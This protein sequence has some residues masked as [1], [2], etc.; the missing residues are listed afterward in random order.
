MLVTRLQQAAFIALIIALLEGI[1][2]AGMVRPTMIPPPHDIFRAF[3]QAISSGFI[4]EHLAATFQR[5]AIAFAIAT[6]LGILIGVGLWRAPVLGKALE[7]LIASLYAM[8]WIFFYPLLLILLGIGSKPII[9]LAVILGVIPIALNTFIGF[10][11]IRP[12]FLKV[13]RATG[14]SP[15]QTFYK[16]L[17]PAAA[18]Y[19]ISGMKLGFI[20]TFLGVVATE[21]LVSPKGLGF[22]VHFAYEYFQV[23]E[24][25]AYVLFMILLAF[26]LTFSLDR[27]ERALRGRYQ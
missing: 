15:W 19:I 1:T 23:K 6:A 17:A 22:I 27:L 26:T 5:L 21:F 7:P 11:E 25:Y 12:I 8:P 14:C 13:G 3:G 2:L 4:A 9:F 18:P 20:Y 16:I 24:M 10:A